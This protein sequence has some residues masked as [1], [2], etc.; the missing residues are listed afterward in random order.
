MLSESKDPR[1]IIHK[2]RR[3]LEVYDG[4]EL[5]KTFAMVLG[6][7]AAG[8][9][10]VEGDGKTPEGEFYVCT[11]NPNSKFHLSLGL[12]YPSKEDAARGLREGLITAAEHDEI[13]AA[14][15]DG[16]M[17]PQNTA[18]GGEI[19]IH[20]GGAERDWTRGCVALENTEIEELFDL[21]PVGTKVS[22]IP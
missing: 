19:Y 20:G 8:D 16:K 11:K 6:F 22:I 9:K 13:V 14:V 1:I 17:P 18:L 4:D 2:D 21:I 15:E 7:Q 5:I 10:E 12:S 3:S